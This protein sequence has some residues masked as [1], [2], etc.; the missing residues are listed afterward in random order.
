[1]IENITK[2]DVARRQLRE[3][4]WLFFYERDAISVQT[5]AAAAHQVLDDLAK[6][7][8]LVS[9]S[10]NPLI[11]E[12]KQKYWKGKLSAAENYFKHADN[13]PEAA[14]EFRPALTRFFLFDAIQLYHQ[15]TQSKSLF[16]EAIVY[17]RWFVLK[18]PN[19]L[20]EGA[21]K[22]FLSTSV[23]H[24]VD[25]DDFGFMR[26]ALLAFPTFLNKLPSPKQKSHSST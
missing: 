12:E 19:V 8:G 4:I 24:D 17:F 7:K 15:L 9:I 3:A 18:Y 13:D 23:G 1:M 5:L 11:R 10:R 26:M 25:P 16:P 14:F 2:L 21:V 6:R 20:M 22:T